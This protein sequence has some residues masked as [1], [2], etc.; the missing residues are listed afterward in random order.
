M[1]R[2]SAI[3]LAAGRGTRMKS[4]K[5]KILHQVAGKPMINCIID[6][7]KKFKL[8]KIVVVI[9]SEEASMHNHEEHKIKYVFQKIKLGTA[10]AVLQSRGEFQGYKGDIFVLNGD[11]PL[12]TYETLND[13]L[14]EHRNSFAVLSLLT[15]AVPDPAGYGRVIRKEGEIFKIVEELDADDYIKKINEINAGTYCFKG[16]HLF[17]VLKKIRK[18][19]VKN[20]FYLTDAVEILNQQGSKIHTYQVKDNN[21]ILGVNRRHELAKA[22]IIM[23]KR[24]HRKLMDSGVTI[25]DIDSTYIE[26]DVKI[27]SD[28]IIYP[29]TFLY[30]KLILGENCQIGP[31][32]QITE[33]R[34]GNN[35]RIFQSTVTGSTIK[36]DVHVGPYAHIRDRTILDRGSGVGNFM[37]IARSTL[38]KGSRAYHLSY[39]G[40]TKVGRNVNFGA[41]IVTAN[42]D[43]RKKNKTRINDDVY[44][45]S[46]TT[47]IAPV[48]INK[49]KQI[50]AGSIIKK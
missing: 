47:I 46:S 50:P 16:D 43:G 4:K 26:Y 27:G 19:P 40:D 12:I 25:V 5:P 7:L 29:F 15:A 8:D 23:Q 31:F 14:K 1:D 39:I 20:E 9:G 32:V 44:I 35:V 42:F 41:G 10:H 13:L 38:G 28:T 21:E 48:T 24:I 34:I 30:G 2:V 37:E 18:N 3:I 11:V 36:D 45:G 17:P 22:N 49:K 33:S 6:Q